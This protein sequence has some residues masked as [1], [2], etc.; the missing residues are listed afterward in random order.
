MSL[1]RTFQFMLSED[2]AAAVHRYFDLDGTRDRTNY[3][4]STLNTNDWSH[5]KNVAARLK[6]AYDLRACPT[7][8]PQPHR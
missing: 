1:A 5:L 4:G 6:F 7:C 8:G 3:V 2:E